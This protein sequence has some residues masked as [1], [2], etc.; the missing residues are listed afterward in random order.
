MP[1]GFNSKELEMINSVFAKFPEIEKVIIFGSR[2][3]GNFKPGS[4]VDLALEGSITDDII[5]KVRTELNE[6]LPLPYI[7]D[8][9]DR[10]SISNEA[11]QSHIS[12]YGEVFYH[13]SG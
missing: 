8:I 12:E 1:Y 7:F 13:K 10:K 4:D 9:F 5:S 6:E 2:A 11:L 3:M